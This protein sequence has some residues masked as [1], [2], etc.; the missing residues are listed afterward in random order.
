MN[1]SVSILFY[2]K[3]AKANNL[4]YVPFI[5]ELQLMLNGL[6]LT[7]TNTGYTNLASSQ[8]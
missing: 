4:G 6:S 8:S 5:Q 1:T 7:L 2:I 3:R